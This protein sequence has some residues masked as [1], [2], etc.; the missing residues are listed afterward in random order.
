MAGFNEARK[1]TKL[2][3]DMYV[4]VNAMRT[5]IKDKALS[6]YKNSFKNQ[7]F[8]DVALQPWKPLKRARVR[9]K[10]KRG[11]QSSKILVKS[12]RL[13]DSLKVR[14]RSNKEEAVITIFSKVKYANIHNEGLMGLAFG[15]HPFRMPKRQFVG[16]ST[17]LDKRL[18]NI[19]RKKINTIFNKQ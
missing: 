18:T 19:F 14:M 17:I 3:K 5:E 9:E 2:Q 7:G 4:G 1:L 10:G 16:Y 13:R 11:R 8:T 15:K 12:G 6:F